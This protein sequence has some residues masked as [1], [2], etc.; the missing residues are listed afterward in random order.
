MPD[1]HRAAFVEMSPHLADFLYILKVCGFFE[2]VLIG[3]IPGKQGAPQYLKSVNTENE[4]PT[5]PQ[6]INSRRSINT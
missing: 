4:R 2:T 3:S 1:V 6:A 5:C